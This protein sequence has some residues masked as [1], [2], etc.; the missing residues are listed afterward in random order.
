MLT[1]CITI[2]N[3]KWE[4]VCESLVGIFRAYYELV[5]MDETYKDRVS[6]YLICDGIDKVSDEFLAAASKAKIYDENRLK[7]KAFSVKEKEEIKKNEL[8]K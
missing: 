5:H 3:E 1:I 2:Y 7:E 6:V 8:I 4:Q